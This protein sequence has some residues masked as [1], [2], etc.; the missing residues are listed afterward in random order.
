MINNKPAE[1]RSVPI[2]KQLYGDCW[3]HAICRNFIRTLQVLDVIKSKYNK[4]FYDLFYSVLTENKD[5][6]K[7]GNVSDLFILFDFLKLNYKVIFDISSNKS[8]CFKGYCSDAEEYTFFKNMDSDDKNDFINKMADLFNRDILFVGK[9]TYTIN[10]SG[11]NK[12]SLAIRTMLECK[13]QPYVGI[14]LNKYL[15]NLIRKTDSLQIQYDKP[16][17]PDIEEFDNSCITGSYSHAVNL[18]RWKNNYVEFKNSWGGNVADGGNFSVSDLKYLI[19]DGDNI[20]EFASLMFKYNQIENILPYNETFDPNLKIKNEDQDL[21][22]FYDSYGLLNGNVTVYFSDL[23][24]EGDISNGFRE[25]NGKATYT[26][27]DIYEGEWK[28][29]IRKGRGKMTYTNGDIY[30]GNW[31]N[32]VKEGI[33][34][35]TYPSDDIY[36][37]EWKNGNI[38]GNGTYTWKNGDIYRG[39]WKN[40]KIDGSGTCIWVNGNTYKGEWKNN[41]KEG[42]GKMIWSDGRE[43]EGRWKN[44]QKDEW[45]IYKFSDGRVYEGGWKNDQ[46][47]G[48]GIFK[49]LDGRVYEGG[50][51]NDQKDG[52]G[53]FTYSDGKVYD[54]EWKNDKIEG[55]GVYIWKNGDTYGGEWKNGFRNGKGKMTFSHGMVY[56]G[57]WKNDKREGWGKQTDSQNIIIYE[58]DWKDDKPLNMNWK[59]KYIKYKT[60]YLNLQNQLNH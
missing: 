52:W 31:K 28:N 1:L 30:E 5:C 32:N 42:N 48:W 44:N 21:S 24:Y 59:T 11:N 7:G 33:G 23:K 55:N 10:P 47:D 38:E 39:E 37:G 50:W 16:Y 2:Q 51:K 18:R 17:I 14:R 27:G 49:W 54:G 57:D 25:G 15:K 43:Y 58:G 9:Y 13:L 12:P 6:N 41:N 19:C 22:D 3:A 53:K 36:E 20:V 56:D 8:E 29:N 4:Q 35:M 34:K 46:K 45:G 40:N 26:N 60:K